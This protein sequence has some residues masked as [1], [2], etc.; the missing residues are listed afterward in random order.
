MP[1]TTSPSQRPGTWRP[2][3]S[4]GRASMWTG[5]SR[6]RGAG[7]GP[8]PP[9][10]ALQ[11]VRRLISS[12]ARVDPGWAHTPTGRSP[13]ET[14]GKTRRPRTRWA[15]GPRSTPGPHTAAG[16]PPRA[17]APNAP[18]R[19]AWAAPARHTPPRVRPRSNSW[20]IR[21]SSVR[22]HDSDHARPPP[23]ADH[24]WSGTCATFW[25]PTGSRIGSGRARAPTAGLGAAGHAFPTRRAL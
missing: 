17:A 25:N 16:R 11:P 6:I 8:R 24:R 19:T 15:T 21:C 5:S 13:H 1:I 2:V 4:A 12:R 9:L 18:R 23:A 10:R 3:T 20:K 14:P 22:R 7:G